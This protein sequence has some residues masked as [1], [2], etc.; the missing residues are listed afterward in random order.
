MKLTPTTTRTLNNGV[1]DPLMGFGLYQTPKETAG[2]I[3]Y[4]ALKAGYRRID[5]AEM[6]ENEAES[7]EGIAKFLKDYPQ[8]SRSDI[9][10][11]T[12]LNINVHGTEISRKAIQESLDKA[13]SIGYVDLF[14]IH[15]PVSGTEKRLQAYGALQ[16]F[17][18]AKKIR[19]IG[20]SNYSIK[21]L[22]ELFNWEGYKVKPAVNQ[23]EASPWL[24]RKDLH[25]YCDKEGIAVETFSPITRGR[26]LGDPNVAKVL[27][28][29]P[30]HTAAQVLLRWQLQMGFLPAVKTVHKERLAENLGAFDLELSED[31]MN[32]LTNHEDHFLAQPGFDPVT[33]CD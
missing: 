3:V 22:E 7:V 5:S 4:E 23:I 14:L 9:F 19:A 8:V 31:E 18:E 10:Y 11:T 32:T 20:V 1:K 12:K 25:A 26:K 13:K 2:T 16:E 6:Y 29:H 30:G 24:T 17:Y 15:Q 21:H 28:N 27:K 33:K